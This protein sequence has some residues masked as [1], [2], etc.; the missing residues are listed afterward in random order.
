MPCFQA[1]LF[2]FG[3]PG[4][5][6]PCIRQRPFFIGRLLQRPPARVLAPHDALTSGISQTPFPQR[7]GLFLTFFASLPC[8]STDMPIL[9]SQRGQRMPK[10]NH[11]LQFITLMLL[12]VSSAVL[13]AYPDK[14]IPPDSGTRFDKKFAC[15]YTPNE[16]FVMSAALFEPEYVTELSPKAAQLAD[17]LS[18]EERTQFFVDVLQIAANRGLPVAQLQLGLV[19]LNGAPGLIQNESKALIW[20]TRAADQGL[21]D[22]QITASALFASGVGAAPDYDKAYFWSLISLSSYDQPLLPGLSDRPSQIRHKQK[23]E[24]LLSTDR[25]IAMQATAANWEPT[26]IGDGCAVT[27]IEE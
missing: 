9:L 16:L 11:I 15:S 5:D 27:S 10:P 3:A 22:A 20:I 4:L 24:Q 8:A 19:H 17:S 12:C 18:V 6:P 14:T 1:Y 2:P 26:K 23:L 13:P 21:V 25:R 7:M